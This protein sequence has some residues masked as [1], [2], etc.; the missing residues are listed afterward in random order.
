M[1]KLSEPLKAFINAAHARPNTTPAPRHIA[2][3]YEKIAKDAGSKKV[4]MPAW[5]T[6]STAATMTMNSPQSLLEL[7]GLATSPN[8]S[9][10][11]DNK[12]WTAELMREVGLKCIGL[13]G[14]PRTINSLGAFYNG[15]PQ[16][17]QTELQKRKPRRN[18]TP[19]TLPTTLT[20]GNTLWESIY[21][22]FS[23]KLT[24]KLA[25]SH[26]DLPVFI[27]E[28]EYGALFSDP[29]NPN[30]NVPNIGRVLMSLLAVSV[31]RAQTGVGPQVVSHMFGL[32]K[33]FEDG[34]AAAEGAVEGG[35]WLAGDEGGMWMLGVVDG[36][37]GAIGE[38]RGT[39][40]APGGEKAKL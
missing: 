9:K 8:Y 16:D 34:T 22:P 14:V 19:Q 33:A 2:S 5:L 24:S 15:L 25:Q 39:S 12:V 38:G 40:F 37:V 20:R 7:Y 31:L 11:H 30:P 1:S 35:E 6:V 21:R 13:N 26:P 3:V 32:R 10:G 27:I 4:G 17:V 28:A 29:P 18:L 36:I 23:S